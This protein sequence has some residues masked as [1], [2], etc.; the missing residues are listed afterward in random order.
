MKKDE[1]KL[2]LIQSIKDEIEVKEE[3]FSN[4]YID[5]NKKA[6]KVR[7]EILKLEGQINGINLAI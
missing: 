7:K 3:E 6:G 5:A 4:I 1:L 2:K